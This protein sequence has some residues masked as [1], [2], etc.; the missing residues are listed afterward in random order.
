MRSPFL[1]NPCQ[2]PRPDIRH[3]LS[4]ASQVPSLP[5]SCYSI[6][7]PAMQAGVCRYGQAVLLSKQSPP[8]ENDTAVVTSKAF[9]AEV[10]LQVEHMFT[11]SVVC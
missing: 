8:P 11:C 7:P 4:T 3:V 1:M 2:L 6:L 9:A 5:T 10:V